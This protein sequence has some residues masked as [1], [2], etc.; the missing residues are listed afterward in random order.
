MTYRRHIPR[1]PL[2]EFVELLWVFEGALPRHASERV[3]PTGTLE[4]VINLREE[5]DRSFD[6]V[7]AGPHSRFFMLDTSRPASVIGVHFKPSGAFP[8]F[9][10]PMDEL[11]NQ[12]VPLEALWGKR[13]TDLRERLLA[14]ATDAAKLMLLER[15]LLDLLH[16]PDRRHAAVGHALTT[17]YRG[18]RRI[19]DVV[20]EIGMSQRRFIRLFSDEVGLTPKSFCR[21][22]RFQRTLALLQHAQTVDWAGTALAAGYCD[23]SHMIHDFQDLAGVTP[24][25]YLSRRTEH[26]NHVRD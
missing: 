18:P 6:S 7:V 5:T 8:F 9:T 14:T 1:S 22:R 20:D 4:L 23:Q 19:A 2:S 26:A 12:H 11:R 13:A 16:R 25:S 3:L 15:A 24:A 21:V 10:L 17:F